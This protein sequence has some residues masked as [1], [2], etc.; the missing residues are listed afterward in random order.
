M[1]LSSN[2]TSIT[3]LEF[4]ARV[5]PLPMAITVR[6]TQL[7]FWWADAATPLSLAPQDSL[8]GGSEADSTPPLQRLRLVI[9][10]LHRSTNAIQLPE[11]RLWSRLV[12]QTLLGITFNTLPGNAL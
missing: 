5:K 2:G 1:N 11:R 12:L 8:R 4:G 7:R 10:K 3:Y 9:V 6:K